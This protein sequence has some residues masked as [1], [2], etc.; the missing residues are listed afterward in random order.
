MA[1]DLS[2]KQGYEGR[3]GLLDPS[4]RQQSVRNESGSD[5]APG[6]L[7]VVTGGSDIPSV[8]LI[9]ASTDRP[10]G[11]ALNTTMAGDIDIALP[12]ADVGTI[13]Y[14]GPVYVIPEVAVDP[15]DPVYVRHTAHSSPGTYDAIGR[16]RNDEDSDGSKTA[17]ELPKC[18]WIS[19]SAAGG[20][21][22][23]EFAL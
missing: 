19:A 8:K 6:R 10:L 9:S 3:P 11:V 14:R 22:I 20:L 12:D 1:L 2:L 7:C 5:I 15:S 21:A 16:F 13:L 17:M 4:A 23:L 18:R